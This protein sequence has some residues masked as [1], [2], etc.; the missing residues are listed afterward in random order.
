MRAATSGEA[1][2]VD[3]RQRLL[4]TTGAGARLDHR[5]VGRAAVLADAMQ[6]QQAA[7]ELEERGLADRVADIAIEVRVTRQMNS[8]PIVSSCRHGWAPTALRATALNRRRAPA[9]PATD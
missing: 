1:T 5:F 9:S 3:G 2:A 8:A 4:R 7:V 6:Q